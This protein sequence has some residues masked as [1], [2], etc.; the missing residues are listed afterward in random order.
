MMLVAII[1]GVPAVLALWLSIFM[2]WRRGLLWLLIFVPFAGVVT[3]ALRP[4]PIGTLVKDL[5]I[6]IPLY[7]VFFLLHTDELRRVKI[8]NTLT[9]LLVVF[10]GL[11][12][13]QLFNPN[14]KR[15]VVGLVGVKVWLMYLPLIYISAAYFKKAED[16]VRVLR[17]SVVIGV[18]P[19]VLGI[20]QFAMCAAIG[21]EETMTLF[22]RGS[23]AAVT[24]NFAS[25]FMGAEFYR[26]PSTFSY[27]TQYSGYCLMMIAV[28]Y[29]LQS[30]EPDAKW[31]LFARVMMGVVFAACMLS[32]A[33]A[34]FAFAPMLYLMIL[35]LDAKLT[36]MAAGLVFGP[37]VMI[38]TLQAMGLD[39]IGIFGA[40]GGLATSYGKDLVLAELA[41]S[42]AANPLGQ[43]VG[44]NTGAALNLMSAN[45]KAVTH[46]IEGYYSKAVI[47][48]GFVGMML[49][50]MIFGALILSGI[51]LRKSLRDPMA[52]SAASVILAFF[53]IMVLHSGKGWQ[54]DLDPINV[55]YWVFVGILFRLPY[56]DF[57]EVSRARSIAEAER[58][59]QQQRGRKRM[60]PSR[61]RPGTAQTR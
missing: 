49:V 53:V 30:I 15:F 48:L 26:I 21:Y 1:V 2:D 23:A 57:S 55:W 12:L 16:L 9:M 34:N 29:M 36:R 6:V 58:Q 56:L 25:F 19:C 52:R 7:A 60:R 43:G 37:I 8:P 33:R 41:Q 18:V 42:I 4:S 17:I 22:Y 39:A 11:V 3:I 14:I 35:F 40:T 46:N 47:E 13:L 44:T 28:V 32:G 54:I 38:S 27:V 20:T 31:R 10:A 24:Q 61:G 50:I 51:Q 59:A 5:A 45:E